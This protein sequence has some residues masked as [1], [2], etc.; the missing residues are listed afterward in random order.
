MSKAPFPI[1]PELTAIAVMY[2]N[3]KMIADQVAPRV[4]VGK[5]VF[6]YLKHDMAEGF[7]VPDTKVGRKSAPNR[8][9][10]NASEVTDSTEDFGLDDPIPQ[11]DILN[12][13]PNY[14]PL[15]KSV[16]FTSNLIEL[17]REVRVANKVFNADNY[18]SNN[19]MTLS[20]SDQISDPTSDPIGMFTDVLD[21]MVMRGNIMVVGRPAYSQLVRHPD[22]VSG[23]NRN[24]GTK[25][26]ASKEYLMELFE[27]DDILVGEA[28]VNTARKGQAANLA[29]AWGKHISFVYRDMTADVQRGLTYM[30]TPQF[31]TRVA[32][33]IPDTNIGL[34]GGQVVRVG[35]SVKEIICANDLAYF[36][37]NAV[38]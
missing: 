30:L 28:F 22:I 36:V 14:D 13:P 26:K 21:G 33:S 4:P 12:A 3:K 15:G 11:S 29:R 17:D 18:G 16:L 9:E 10:F 37:Q 25:G 34:R 1:Q 35:E 20:G 8:V 31:G 27:L 32:G 24:A 38:A 23:F 7:T 2:S 5:E 19:K 6:K